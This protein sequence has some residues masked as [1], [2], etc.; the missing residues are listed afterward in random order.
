M[1]GLE[2]E[3]IVGGVVEEVVEDPYGVSLVVRKG[4]K[5]MVVDVEA[6]LDFDCALPPECE[7]AVEAYVDV[8]VWEEGGEGKS[9]TGGN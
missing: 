5:R 9:D 7:D 3:D 4:G 1:E 6:R 8:K 2:P